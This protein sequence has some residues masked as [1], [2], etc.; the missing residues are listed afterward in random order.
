MAD[1]IPA[2]PGWYVHETDDEGEY[3]DPVV[4]WKATT[5]DDGGDI[6][7]PAVDAGPGYP[8]FF[9]TTDAFT[10]NARCVV[11]RPNYDPGAEQ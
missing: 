10:H 1:F 2:G 5:D 7:L 11:Y 3:L 8:P 4:A 9:L 6:L